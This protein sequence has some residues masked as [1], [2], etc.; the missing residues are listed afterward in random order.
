[1]VLSAA[2]VLTNSFNLFIAEEMEAQRDCAI[3]PSFYS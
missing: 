2:Y 3:D 1:M